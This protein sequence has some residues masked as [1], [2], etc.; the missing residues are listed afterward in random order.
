MMPPTMQVL[1]YPHYVLW[2]HNKNYRQTECA[3]CM[4]RR[5]DHSDL[6]VSKVMIRHKVFPPCLL[7]IFSPS[8]EI[9]DRDLKIIVPVELDADAQ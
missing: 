1:H 9:A 7:T 4:Q 3:F 2:A 8:V 5:L 6:A